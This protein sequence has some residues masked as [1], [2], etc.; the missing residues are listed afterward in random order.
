M[1]ALWGPGPGPR[2]AGPLRLLT[3]AHSAPGPG[4]ALL[5]AEAG[6]R[7]PGRRGDLPP[8]CFSGSLHLRGRADGPFRADSR[9]RGRALRGR[10]VKKRDPSRTGWPFRLRP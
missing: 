5:R 7:W 3:A 9:S 4:L 6:R 1:T 2:S 8:A 10:A